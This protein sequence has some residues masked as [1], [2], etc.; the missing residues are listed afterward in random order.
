MVTSYVL[1]N[2]CNRTQ[3]FL[4]F[5][6]FFSPVE[7]FPSSSKRGRENNN[8]QWILCGVFE[9]RRRRHPHKTVMQVLHAVVQ[10]NFFE[11][12]TATKKER[13]EETNWLFALPT[14]TSIRCHHNHTVFTHTLCH[15]YYFHWCCCE[16]TIERKKEEHQLIPFSTI[17]DNNKTDSRQIFEYC[18]TTVVQFQC[19]EMH[20]RWI[21]MISF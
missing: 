15:D 21:A 2:V 4:V 5:F 6:F 10:D 8:A 18:S 17:D 19:D 16:R 14:R 7:L 20:V 11:T 3:I 9:R 1:S 12:T 13:N